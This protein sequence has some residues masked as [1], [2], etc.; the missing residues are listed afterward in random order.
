[1][2]LSRPAVFLDRDGVINRDSGYVHKKNEFHFLDGVFDACLEMSKAGYRLI[3]ITNQAGIARGYY[4]E[5]AYHQLTNW[6]LG[7]FRRHGSKID[8]V[9][10]CPHHP[11]HGIGRYRRDCNCR[12]PAPGMILRAASEHSLDLSRS[13]LVGDKATDIE[14]GRVAGVGCCILVLTGHSP[15]NAG[16]VKADR[17]YADLAEVANALV[18]NQLCTDCIR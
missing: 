9:Y 2:M 11:L 8:A 5:D 14:A 12:K 6:M 13:I 18:N 1:M 7:E 10:Y 17:V 4:T 16:R 3:I 15:G